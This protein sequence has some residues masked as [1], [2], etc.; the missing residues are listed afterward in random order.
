MCARGGSALLAGRPVEADHV[1]GIGVEDDDV[2]VERR[3]T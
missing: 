1:A 2:L 3:C